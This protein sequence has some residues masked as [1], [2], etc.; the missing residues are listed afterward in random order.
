MRGRGLVLAAIPLMGAIGS[1]G[2]AQLATNE[3]ALSW[4]IPELPPLV[5]VRAE[6]FAARRKALTDSLGDGVY[7]F[8]GARAPAQD[9][10]PYQQNPEFRY[11]TGIEEPDATL[12]LI[13]TAGRLQEQLYVQAR[14]PSREVWEGERL[15]PE[16]AGAG[17]DRTS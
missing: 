6:E 4:R 15:G 17:H 2:S 12:I 1:S 16:R 14:N 13:R 9:Y 7:V 11:L 3:S 5:A 8:F 10:L